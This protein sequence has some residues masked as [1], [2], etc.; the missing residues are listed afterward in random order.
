[1]NDDSCVSSDPCVE[2]LKVLAD[3]TRLEVVRR[4][5]H[6]SRLVGE[7]HDGLEVEQSLL[8]HHL[9]ALREAGLVV[10]ERD[11]KAMRYS[12]AEGVRA[13]P[14][15]VDLGCCRLSFD[16]RPVAGKRGR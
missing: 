16:P 13:E 9:R 15:V 8:S 3:R 10:A 4:L 6:G 14:E 5:L 7:L 12:L 2:K 1:M 11:G